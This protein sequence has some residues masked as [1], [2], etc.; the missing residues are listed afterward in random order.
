MKYEK[1]LEENGGCAIKSPRSFR[2][3][4]NTLVESWDLA[5][6]ATLII[7]FFIKLQMHYCTCSVANCRKVLYLLR[8]FVSIHLK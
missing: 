6:L 1:A 8:N 2:T 4:S 5:K 7:L 3:S